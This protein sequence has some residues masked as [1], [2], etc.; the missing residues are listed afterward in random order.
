MTASRAER[1]VRPM[2]ATI[3]TETAQSVLAR[4]ARFVADAIKIRYF[5]FA[6]DHGEGGYLFD[7]DG[8]RYLDFGASWALAGLGYSNERVRDAIKRQ[9]DRSTFGGLLS[10]ANVPAADL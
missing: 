4:D 3:S 2:S 1:R 8:R 7:V 10:S 5:P 9:V 6:L